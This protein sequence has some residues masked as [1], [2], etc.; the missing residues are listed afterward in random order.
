MEYL[1][2]A[3]TLALGRPYALGTLLLAS[4]Y[5]AMSKY[6][7]DEQYHRVSGALW[8]VQMWLFAYFPKLSDRKPTSYKTLGL[9]VV[10]SLHMMPFDD[11]MSFFLGLVDRALVHLF[12]RH[13]YVHISAWNQILV[14]LSYICMILRVMWPL[15]V[16][17]VEYSFM[18]VAS[19]FLLHCLH[20]QLVRNPISLVFGPTSLVFNSL[21]WLYLLCL[22]SSQIWS[23]DR[24]WLRNIK[25]L[26]APL[27]LPL[28]PQHNPF[29]LG[30]ISDLT[31]SSILARPLK[32]KVSFGA[33]LF[34]NVYPI[35]SF[36]LQY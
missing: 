31:S 28:Y 35:S 11:L 9:H 22:M 13:D 23:L 29:F 33:F 14:L 12:F 4:I 10:H 36:S 5:Q 24:N 2:L 30:G 27:G 21:S 32:V 34:I 15:L 26:H 6:V 1:P 17:L 3:K 7:Y 20:P 18:D 16:P 25:L 19:H 8:F